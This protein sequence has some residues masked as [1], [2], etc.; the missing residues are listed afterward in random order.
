[1]LIDFNRS[2]DEI[3]NCKM[4]KM[5]DEGNPFKTIKTNELP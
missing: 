5:K 3:F 4:F 2:C 1:M